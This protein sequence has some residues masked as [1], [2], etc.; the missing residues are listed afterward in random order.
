[1]LEE[2][3]ELITRELQQDNADPEL[4][5]AWDDALAISNVLH[6]DACHISESE[7]QARLEGFH[8]KNVCQRRPRMTLIVKMG[9]GLAATV[10]CAVFF[11]FPHKAEDHVVLQVNHNQ[12]VAN[13]RYTSATQTNIPVKADVKT[14][15]PQIDMKVINTS[16]SNTDTI[17][18]NVP[19]G[20]SCKVELPDGSVAYLHPGSTLTYPREFD[21]R[22]RTVRLDG[23]AY[24][25]IAKNV[26]KPFTVTTDHSE[27][28]VT[29]TEFDVT[30]WHNQDMTVTLVNGSVQFLAK[31]SG[32]KVFLSPGQQVT[33]KGEGTVEVCNADTMKF[34]AWRD[35]F[36]YFEDSSLSDILRQ[37]SQSYNISYVCHNPKLLNYRMHLFIRR[38]KDLPYVVEA[39]NKMKKVQASI[40][41][42][43]LYIE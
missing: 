1:M 8:Q 36:L 17:H 22:K 20:N 13:E 12:L 7:V 16:F 2:D 26:G 14:L 18:L 29:G 41:N 5:D 37:I 25:V 31:H 15:E 35:G 6:Q 4:Q 33:L 10:L 32:R 40:Q 27:T 24:F 43:K 34:V 23:E 30:S 3:S 39:L 28:L 19:K 11:L 42:G 38:D 9:I 21:R